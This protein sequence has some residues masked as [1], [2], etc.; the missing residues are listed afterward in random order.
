MDDDRLNFSF[1]AFALDSDVYINMLPQI[2]KDIHGNFNLKYKLRPTHN[3]RSSRNSPAR[4]PFNNGTISTTV[5]A[6][7][8]YQ[9]E[10]Q[11]VA[12]T[13]VSIFHPLGNLKLSNHLQYYVKDCMTRSVGESLIVLVPVHYSGDRSSPQSQLLLSDIKSADVEFTKQCYNGCISKVATNSIMEKVTS[14]M[15]L[16]DYVSEFGNHNYGFHITFSAET[17]SFKL[18]LTWKNVLDGKMGRIQI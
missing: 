1:R 2:S 16:S 18:L 3:R 15:H 10:N 7:P 14:G 4:P 17:T 12:T 6:C 11:M 5:T 9:L 13:V 8:P